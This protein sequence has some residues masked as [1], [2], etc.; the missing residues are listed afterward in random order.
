MAWKWTCF[1]LNVHFNKFYICFPPYIISV[2]HL[3]HTFSK[4]TFTDVKTGLDKYCM[5]SPYAWKMNIPKAPRQTSDQN[6]FQKIVFDSANLPIPWA[7]VYSINLSKRFRK[8][9]SSL[10]A[11]TDFSYPRSIC[12]IDRIDVGLFTGSGRNNSLLYTDESVV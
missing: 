3:L 1:K 5:N 7:E 6:S 4:V 2:I 12:C 8:L 10:A 9:L 11:C